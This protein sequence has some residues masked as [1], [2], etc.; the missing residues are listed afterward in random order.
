[1]Q[2]PLH[3]PPSPSYPCL[4]EVALPH[5]HPLLLQR[6][7]V[8]LHWGIE[9][10]QDQRALFQVMPD[11]AILCYICNWSH[12]LL[13]VYTWVDGLVPGRFWGGESGWLILSFFLWGCKPFSPC[14]NFSIGFPM[15]S[16]MFG[17][18]HSHLYR[19]SSHRVSQGTAISSSCQ[20]ALLGI[21]NSVWVWF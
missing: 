17:C 21:S 2:F 11:K 3:N 4:Y 14:P 12:K 10:S 9:P 8:L 7:S 18:M 15:P 6:P 1:M 5:T 16:Q 13:H 20:Q 19:S